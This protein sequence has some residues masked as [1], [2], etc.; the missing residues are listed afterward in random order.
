M[1]IQ[2]IQDS[3][4]EER[5]FQEKMNKSNSIYKSLNPDSDNPS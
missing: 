5:L 1:N 2:N 3:I 4:I